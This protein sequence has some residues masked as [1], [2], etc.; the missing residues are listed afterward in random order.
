ME[1]ISN[2]EAWVALATLAVLEIVLG[3]DNIIFISILADKLPKERQA[4]ARQLG[5]LL[6]MVTRLALLGTIN[7]IMKL[8]APLFSFV[9]HA[10]SGRDLILVIGGLFLLTK[11]T[12]EIHHRLEGDDEHAGKA[13]AASYGSILLQIAVMDMVFSLDSV[14]TAVG[15]AEDFAVMAIAIVLAVVVMMLA[16]NAVSR[17][18]NDHPTVKML[19]LSFL[20]LLGMTLVAEGFGHHVAKGYIYF[21]MGFSIFVE[22]LNLRA[23]RGRPIQLRRPPR[24]PATAEPPG[25]S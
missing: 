7:L 23:R 13:R 22:A 17:F 6:A 20:L 25:G 3:I 16:A 11:A 8:T 10:F 19:A 4:S 12:R 2:P 14:I 21:A 1:W 5:L 15:L 24:K 18:V 9:G